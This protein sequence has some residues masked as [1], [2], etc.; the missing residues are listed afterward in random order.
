MSITQFRAFVRVGG[1]VNLGVGGRAG[2]HN[3]PL[4]IGRLEAETLNMTAEKN[5]QETRA[6]FYASA[7]LAK[8][9][10][11]KGVPKTRIAFLSM[12]TSSSSE[13]LGSKKGVALVTCL[14]QVVFFKHAQQVN[15]MD[16]SNGRMIASI[17]R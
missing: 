3:A 4:Q 12:V 5:D 1:A 2:P 13:D 16:K 11:A 7:T 17:V 10:Q 8:H 6:A 15:I 9:I 14:K